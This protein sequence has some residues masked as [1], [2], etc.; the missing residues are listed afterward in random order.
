M[1]ICSCRNISTNQFTSEKDLRDRIMQSDFRCGLCQ[2]Q[3]L[4]EVDESKKL[5]QEDVSCYSNR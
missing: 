4:D 2:L 5:N 1:I 3:Y